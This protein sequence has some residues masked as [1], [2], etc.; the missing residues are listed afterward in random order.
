MLERK[1][2]FVVDVVL[3]PLIRIREEDV[4]EDFGIWIYR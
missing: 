4:G 2:Y 3:S 1:V